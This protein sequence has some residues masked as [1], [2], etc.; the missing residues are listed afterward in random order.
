MKTKNIK[1]P[2]NPQGKKVPHQINFFVPQSAMP[3]LHT[4]SP[5]QC[6]SSLLEK[7]ES[8]TPFAEPFEIPPEWVDKGEE[9]MNAELMDNPEEIYMDPSH[10]ELETN[11]PLSFIKKANNDISWLRPDDY[12][13]NANI[14]KEIR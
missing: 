2:K 9:E 8:Y 13:T 10:E 14:D 4:T 12:V 3:N 7:N 5:I 1:D 6:S 11:L